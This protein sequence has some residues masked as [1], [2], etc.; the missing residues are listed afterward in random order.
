MFSS[1]GLRLRMAASYVLVSAAAVVVVELVLWAIVVP[2][3][4]SARLEA[5]RADHSRGQVKAARLATEVAGRL[6]EAVSQLGPGLPDRELLQRAAR[7]E[8]PPQTSHPADAKPQDIEAQSLKQ[9]AEAQDPKAHDSKVQDLKAQGGKPVPTAGGEYGPKPAPA[10]PG[11]KVVEDK[12]Q[13]ARQQ[14]PDLVEQVADPAGQVLWDIGIASASAGR[15][16]AGVAG[17]RPREDTTLV[18]GWWVSWATN[19]VVLTSGGHSRVIGVVYVQLVGADDKG[20]ATAEHSDFSSWLAPGIVVL[21]LLVPVGVL[22][23]LF[24]TRGLIRR[25]RRLAAGTAAMAE[26]D[27]RARIPVS[28]GDEVGRLESGFNSMAERLEAAAAAE[29]ATVDSAAR[30]AEREQ[31]ARN[32]HD[33]VSQELFSASLLAGWLHRDLPPGTE[34]QQEAGTLETALERTMREMRAMLLEL[35]PVALEDSGLNAALYELCRAYEVRLGI[36]VTAD[37][38]ETD[39]E[40]SVEHTVLRIVQEALGNAVRHGEPDEISL[41]LAQPDGHVDVQVSDNGRGFDPATV[42]DRHGM[43]LDLM[44]D[45]VNALSGTF[46]VVSAPDE[47]TTIT[48]RLPS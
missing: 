31:I 32:L 24:S 38:A 18:N 20:D 3:L 30:R 15:L 29:R 7:K 40:P 10:E 28:G 9:K 12:S 14:P 19:P 36:K 25:I 11:G 13:L 34:W 1:S 33:A 39:L 27:L 23:G 47:G 35:R 4:D 5:A 21:L 6:S 16:P 37:L 8:R 46:D 17:S 22:F 45:R 26:G 44:R 42:A 41:R 48:V 2:Q 43:G